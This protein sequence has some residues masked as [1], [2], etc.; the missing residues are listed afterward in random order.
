MIKTNSY[1]MI[2]KTLPGLENVLVD[3]LSG[4]GADKII[5]LKRAVRF[6]GGPELLY[7]SNYQLRTALKILKPIQ[8]FT[9]RN[10]YELYKKARAIEWNKYLSLEHTFVV[11][12]VV[13]SSSFQHSGY[14]ALKVKDAI[15][16]FFMDRIGRRPSVNTRMPDL[17]INVHISNQTCTISLDSTGKSLHKRGYRSDNHEAPLNEVFAA[18]LLQLAGWKPEYN[19]L[20]PMCGSGTIVIEAGL[21]ANGIPPGSFRR[22]FAFQNWLDF[23]PE[24]LKSVKQIPCATSIK[25]G[26]IWGSDRSGEFVS[27]SRKNAECAGLMRKIDIRQTPFDKII[28][29]WS[30][31]MI[32]MNPPYGERMQTTEINLLYRNVGDTLK[33]NYAGFVAWIL[34]SNREALKNIGLQ[35]SKKLTLFNG[36]LEVKF[37]KYSLYQG[38]KKQKAE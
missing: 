24:L 13:F 8:E 28:P 30:N 6:Y 7:L 14:I 21:I 17:M 36:P 37:Q 22:S 15:A 20:D 27:M 10:E 5:P 1:E 31:G 38:S 26:E 19:L 3:E 12:A 25:K 34:S 35:T 32:I 16:D 11:D 23:D 2:A 33:R 9:V 18:G 29:P 4:L